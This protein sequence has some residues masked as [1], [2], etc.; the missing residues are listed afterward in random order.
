MVLPRVLIVSR[1]TIQK[2][3]FLDFV[4][5]YHLDLRVSYGAI[6]M[7][8][9]RVN[10]V[11]MLLQSFEPI[12]GVLCKEEDIIHPFMKLNYLNFRKRI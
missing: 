12:H 11:H 7:I 2:N 9:S 1:R 5:E 4:G 6:P 8:V 3:K 10:G